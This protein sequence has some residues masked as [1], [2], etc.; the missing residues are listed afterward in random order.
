MPAPDPEK[1]KPV[2]SISRPDI[3]FGIA[4]MPR[5]SR[6]FC[7]GSD[8][9]VYELDLDAPKPEPK[10]LGRHDSYVT[11]LA[12]SGTTLISG[13]YDGRL[14]WWNADSR[15]IVRTVPAHSK[16]IRRLAT[17]PMEPRSPASPMTWFA[18][19]GMSRAA[20]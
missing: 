7:G 19:S 2:K 8:F 20:A 12:L 16:W 17:A 18:G 11:C 10:E 14:I 9:S 15:S 1:L 3:I 6:I 4:R 5:T 13:G